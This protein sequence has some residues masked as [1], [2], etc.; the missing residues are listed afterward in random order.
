V[1]AGKSYLM[2]VLEGSLSNI[3]RSSIVEALKS[4]I[5][6]V[7]GIEVVFFYCDGTWSGNKDMRFIFGSIL[8]QLFSR[9]SLATGGK[10]AQHLQSLHSR[11]QHIID[12]VPEIL[13]SVRWISKTLS[14]VY[15]IVDGLDECL[16]PADISSTLLGL[17]T[18]HINVLV[19]S[20]SEKVIADEM[21]GKH[22]LRL[23]DRAV[24]T[25]IAMYIDWRMCTDRGFRR[26]KD[27]MKEYIKDK[28]LEKCSRK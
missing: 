13:A 25:D 8:R 12:P 11:F 2:F 22:Q 1:G 10:H 16:T 20:R 24:Q 18:T 17:A 6:N 26:A 5:L 23:E 27:P 4:E 3:F 9:V 7:N 21:E 15:I 28:L 14:R 19:S